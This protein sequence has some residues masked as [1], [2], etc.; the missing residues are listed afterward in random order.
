METSAWNRNSP[1]T[2]LSSKNMTED[3]VQ[4]YTVFCQRLLKS[5]WLFLI[6]KFQD[7]QP[8]KFSWQACLLP[9]QCKKA[10]IWPPY[11][12]LKN[13]RYIS[14]AEGTDFNHI[15]QRFW[16]PQAQGQDAASRLPNQKA[17]SLYLLCC[18]SIKMTLVAH[19]TNFNSLYFIGFY[20]R[21]E[22]CL[23]ELKKTLRKFNM[24]F[25]TANSA[26]SAIMCSLEARA[27]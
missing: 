22:N 2:S 25:L 13:C 8:N 3:S 21:L 19:S 12:P 10:H 17:E 14:S 20:G 26:L 9:T 24:D 15:L 4:W 7:G 16:P 5:G 27:S 18:H 6:A 11:R 23:E 1:E